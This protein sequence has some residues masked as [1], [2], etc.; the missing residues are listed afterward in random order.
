MKIRI[1]ALL[2]LALFAGC[3]SSLDATGPPPAPQLPRDFQW[4]GRY[5]VS[6]LDVDVPFTWQ[7][8]DGDIQ[9]IAGSEDHEIYFTNIVQDGRL[10]TLTYK[11]PGVEPPPGEP[12]K[13]PHCSCIGQFTLDVL[14]E[15]LAK[16]RYAGA[17]ILEGTEPRSV[18]HFRIGVVLEFVPPPTPIRTPVMLGDFYVDQ[19]D[20][21]KFWEV[22]HFGL[23]NLYDPAL[24]E[25]IIIDTFED[26]PGEVTLPPECAAVECPDVPLT[27]DNCK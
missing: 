21:T 16:S 20:S 10:Y 15:C 8:S 26:T 12:D 25:W 3:S 11:W 1:L 23:H 13:P 27:A 2:A 19:E 24:D 5:L 6:D 14:N 18:H 22:L 17:E 4:E 9:M 7:G